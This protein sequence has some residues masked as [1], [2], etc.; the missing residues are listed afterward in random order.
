MKIAIK[1]FFDSFP[2][3][4]VKI[5]PRPDGTLLLTMRRGE[6]PALNKAIDSTAI[7]CERAMR[8]LIREVQRDIKLAAGEIRFHGEGSQWIRNK[9]P[10]FTGGPIHETASKTLVARRKLDGAKVRQYSQSA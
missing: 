10:T 3:Y 7:F 2:D 5:K 6:L 1:E 8:D 9:L 4:D